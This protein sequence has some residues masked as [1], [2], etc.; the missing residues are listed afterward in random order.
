MEG[1]LD[2]SLT[3][4]SSAFKDGGSIPKK[5]SGLGE[6]ISPPLE[7]NSIHSNAKSIA[8][9]MDDPDAPLPI[10]IIHWVLWNIPIEYNNI[11]EN[12][13]HSKIVKELGNAHQGKRM[14]GKT[15]YMG[16]NPPFGVHTYRFHIY[17]LDTFLDIKPEAKFKQL[18]SKMEGHILQYSLF[19]GKFSKK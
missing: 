2:K 19:T 10:T 8:I 6:E 3:V 16:P 17:T 9:V 7:I 5:Y 1:I 11:P 18:K 13:P 4:T 12:I 15:G 14:F